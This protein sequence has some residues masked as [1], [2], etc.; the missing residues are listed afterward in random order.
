MNIIP[1]ID[2]RHGKV[3]QLVGGDPDQVAVEAEHTPLE[4]AQV[5]RQ[6][7]ATLLHV[8]DLDAALGGARQWHHLDRVLQTGAAIQFGGGVRSMLDVQ[9]LLDNG[10]RQ[11]II[12]T[13]GVQNPDW[14]REIA[15]LWPGR[16]ILAVDARGRDVQVKGWTESAGTDAVELAAS[17]DDAGLGG[18]LYTNVEKEGQLNGMDRDV[19][20]AL[21]DATPNTRLTISGGITD[22]S[23][24]DYLAGIGVDAVVLGMSVYTGRIDLA[25]AI[26][27]YDPP[28]APANLDPVVEP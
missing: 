16:V 13:Q 24:L 20:R 25:K 21:R 26:Q 12:G 14:L 6:A 9:K 5:W 10:V 4:Q 28:T 2:L 11:V 7:G 27:R 18:F 15:T 3:V 17:L 19:V 22:D 23:D 1:A 8:V